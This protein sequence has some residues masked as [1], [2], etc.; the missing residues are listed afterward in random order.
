MTPEMDP[1]YFFIIGAMKAGTTSLYK[2]LAGHPQLYASPRKEPR[3]FRDPADPARL[4]AAFHA[5]FAGRREESWCFEASTAYTKYPLVSG[6]PRRL[7][8]V[9]PE[10]RFVYLVRNPVERSWSHYVHNL[11]HGREAQRF[12]R[13]LAKRPQYLDTSRYHLQLSRYHEVFPR[14]RMLVQ[15]FEEMVADPVATVRAVCGFLGVDCSYRPPTSDVAYNASSDK[16]AASRPL[17]TVR[18]LGMDEIIPGR[19]RHWLQKRGSPLPAKKDGLTPELRAQLVESLREDTERFFEH[20]GRRIA[21][22]S[23]FA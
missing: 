3:V 13:A 20:L 9:V 18:T 14:E 4:R 16:L 8:V 22:W 15:V 11:A 7:Q 17:R 23:D 6:V 2:Y 1:Q 19:V 12:D 21:S 5:L 10:A